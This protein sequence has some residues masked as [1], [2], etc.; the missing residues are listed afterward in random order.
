MQGQIIKIRSNIYEVESEGN[1]YELIL[2]G[3]FR[4]D[5]ILPRVGDY[6]IFDSNTKTIDKILPRKNEFERPFVSNIDQAFIVISLKKPEFSLGLLDRFLTLM[7]LH[8]V[9]SIICLTKKDLISKEELHQLQIV[10]EYY[11]QLGYEV[12]FN[13][14]LDRIKQLIKGKTSV[15]TGQTGAGKSTLLNHLNPSWNLA[16]GEISEA[17]GR[18]KHTTRNVELYQFCEGKVLDTPGFSALDFSN[19]TKEEIQNSFREFDKYVCPFKDCAHIKEKTCSVKEA[20]E[21][22]EILESRYQHYIK[23]LQEVSH[24]N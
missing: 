1:V 19:Y 18:G 3:I 21:N 4:K 15:F 20:V 14:E 6:V 11:H 7:E 17:L 22:K 2:R 13:D 12:L 5:K 9:D 24:V 8:Q 16:T 10:L 23:F